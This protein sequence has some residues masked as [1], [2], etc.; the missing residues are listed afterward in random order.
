MHRV[1]AAL[2]AVASC[3]SI[4]QAQTASLP[5]AA[6]A[7]FTLERA[8]SLAAGSSPS[9][10]AASAGVRAAS[11][12]RAVAG[13]RPNPSLVVESENIVGTGDYR[14][15]RSAETTA[16][17]QLPIELGGKRSARIGVADG[18][19]GRQR[20]ET[21]IIL[22]DLRQRVTDAYVQAIAAERRLTIAD[23]Q[24]RITADGL[25][26]AGD[27]VQVGAASPIE[28]ER[29]AVLDINARA[30]ALSA[31]QARDVS[32]QA[33]ER[34]IGQPLGAPLDI[35]WFDRVAGPVTGPVAPDEVSGTLDV[36]AAT[37]DVAIS[38]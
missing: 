22:A 29:A 10:E 24:A 31:R 9:V 6:E 1:I 36:A 33:L 2:A 14:G 23:D 26:V 21:A 5:A 20:I 3:A 16:S 7:P 15:V 38:R 11:A 25:K 27:R 19:I 32:R 30:A 37:A 8:L 13:L 12:G 18:R 17:V 35:A 4:A 28:Q 34:L